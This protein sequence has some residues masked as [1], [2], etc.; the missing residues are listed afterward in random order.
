MDGYGLNI[1]G[2]KKFWVRMS[3][4]PVTTADGNELN[5]WSFTRR[6]R[7]LEPTHDM[8]FKGIVQLGARHAE[9]HYRVFHCLPISFLQV[10]SRPPLVLNDASTIGK[11]LSYSESI[12][13]S[14]AR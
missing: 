6:C 1:K 3:A 10:D 5:G 4:Q 8:A 14:Y 11:F 2:G 12:K 7:W 9:I 13:P